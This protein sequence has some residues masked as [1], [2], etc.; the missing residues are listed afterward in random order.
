[1]KTR[2]FVSCLFMLTVF[3]LNAQ[4]N[5]DNQGVI[6]SKDS[7]KLLIGASSGSEDLGLDSGFLLL[8]S[9]TNSY[10]SVVGG[11]SKFWIS[12]NEQHGNGISYTNNLP[13][14]ICTE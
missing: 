4:H 12:S 13:L 10:L 2:F 14:F 1:M 8:H 9:D 11:D 6:Y 7:N 5:Y 3:C